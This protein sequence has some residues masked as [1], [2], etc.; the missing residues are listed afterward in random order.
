MKIT[1]VEAYPYELK[2]RIPYR[3]AIVD[4]WESP[5]AICV[6]KSDQDGLYGVGQATTSA[7][8]YAPFDESIEDILAGIRRVAPKLVGV[9][10]WDIEEIHRIMDAITHGHRYAHCCVDLAVHDLLGKAVGVPVWRLLGG[11]LRDKVWV[12]APH[13][14]YL[15]PEEMAAEARAYTDQGFKYINLRAGKDLDEDLAIL[16]AVRDEI[17]YEICIDMDFS[18]SLSMHQRR[19]DDAIR[20]IRHLEEYKINSFEQPL[21]CDD[22]KGMKRLSAAIETPIFADES[23]FCFDDILRIAEMEAADGIKIKMVKFGGLRGAVKAAQLADACG[24][25]MSVGHG[26]CGSLQNSGELHLAATV[27]NLKS[28]GEMV[29]F[30]R[31]KEDFGSGLVVTDGQLAVPDTPGLGIK[32]DLS[33]LKS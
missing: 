17:G 32:V 6:V 8:R 4:R 29:G 20:Y 33:L 1:S 9:N 28:P 10:A 31:M 30:T 26:L 7:P 12:T 22:Y 2:M 19:P 14:G 11:R 21:A 23:V 25:S 3:T 24:L 5:V 18:Q 27:G 13:I 16:K 15:A